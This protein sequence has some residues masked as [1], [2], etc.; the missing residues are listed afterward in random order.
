M[1]F[2]EW[3]TQRQIFDSKGLFEALSFHIASILW[4]VNFV[5]EVILK[6]GDLVQKLPKHK[7][8]IGSAIG[9]IMLSTKMSKDFLILGTCESVM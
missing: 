5:Y 6:Y 3:G 4:V 7:S 1:N 9:R 8:A 2:V